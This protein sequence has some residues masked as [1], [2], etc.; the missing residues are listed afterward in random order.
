MRVTAED[1]R[2]QRTYTVAVERLPA[3]AAP[4]L[5]SLGPAFDAL[6]NAQT[7]FAR[8]FT[9]ALLFGGL[10]FSLLADV[11]ARLRATWT[12]PPRP[13]GAAPPSQ[14]QPR[15]PGSAP[16]RAQALS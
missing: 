1:G 7:T 15:P 2:T 6:Q 11:E 8:T 5:R 16:D 3:T 13:A 4:G 10:P 14:P 12:A 9:F